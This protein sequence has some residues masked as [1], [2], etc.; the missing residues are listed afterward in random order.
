ML[1]ETVVPRGMGRYGGL[2]RVEPTGA[3]LAAELTEEMIAEAM[4]R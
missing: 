4:A 2:S 3:H 1:G